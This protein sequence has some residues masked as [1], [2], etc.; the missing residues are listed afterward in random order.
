MPKFDDPAKEAHYA[1]IAETKA[2]DREYLPEVETAMQAQGFKTLRELWQKIEEFQQVG[3]FGKASYPSLPGI[4]SGSTSPYTQDKSTYNDNALAVEM[5][6]KTPIEDLFDVREDHSK[7]D[8]LTKQ[9]TRRITDP[10]EQYAQDVVTNTLRELMQ[11]NLTPEQ[12][13][14]LEKRNCDDMPFTEIAAE[15]REN[16][17]YTL[18]T[19]VKRIQPIGGKAMSILR[20]K[21]RKGHLREF[22][23]ASL[24]ANDTD[25]PA[26]D[27]GRRLADLDYDGWDGDDLESLDTRAYHGPAI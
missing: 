25:N 8:G 7:Y 10:E 27:E 24:P 20:N 15:H 19:W 13:E 3:L 6:L 9:T 12:R 4:L 2:K 16:D 14:I 11:Q 21:V 1:Q 5:A 26:L 18:R 23:E 17:S 22:L